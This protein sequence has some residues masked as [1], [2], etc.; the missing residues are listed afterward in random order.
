MTFLNLRSLLRAGLAVP[1]T[2]LA[3]LAAA[4]TPAGAAT[5]QAGH[6]QAGH[7]HAAAPQAALTWH[8]LKLANGWKSASAPKLN[9]GKPAWAIRDGVVYLRGAVTDTVSGT[10][11]FS[12]LPV[13]ARPSRD[14][15]IEVY[16]AND[17]SGDLFIS[18]G[19]SMQAYYGQATT[20]TS[21][22]T[23]S[24]PTAAVAAHRLTLKNG[25]RS[26]QSQ[27]Q[28]GNP[29]YAVSHGVVYLS[30][31]LHGGASKLAFVLPKAARPA[32]LMNISVYTMDG[33]I[34]WLTIRSTG[35]VRIGG[36]GS[37]DYTSLATISFPVAST[38]WHPFKL[39]AD[40]H[41]G[42]SRF[43]TGAPSY[44]VVNG[45]VFLAGSMYQSAAGTTGLWTDVPAAAQPRHVLEIKAYM[46]NGAVGGVAMTILG[47]VSSNPFSNAQAYT[48]LAGISYPPSS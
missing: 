5:A 8:A 44:A 19:G 21:L 36:E 47:L 17:T 30:G 42:A 46:L 34:G 7:G 26:S 2:T 25:W 41:S 10:S 4:G 27:Y 12:Q 23:V 45:V 22:S 38:K 39:I 16:T 20:F 31:S 29:S 43:R 35:Q 13:G 11:V 9:T 28:T 48:S 6:A 24:F 3:L 18:T 40:W 32:H 14:L 33:S 15:Y 37:T 1:A